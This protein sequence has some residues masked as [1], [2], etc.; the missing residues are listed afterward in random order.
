MKNWQLD[1]DQDGIAVLT[2]DMP[3]R[4]MNVLNESSMSEFGEAVEE[5]SEDEAIKGIVV[6]SGKRDF[7]AGAD[8]SMLGESAGNRGGEGQDESAPESTDSETRVKRLYQANLGFNQL[9]RRLETCGKPVAAALPGTALGGG[10]E[11]A[12]AC[13]YRVLADNPRAQIGLPEA[14]VGVMPGGGGTQRLPRMIGAMQALPLML[15]GKSLDPASAKAMGIVDEVV[16]PDQ[17]LSAAKAWILSNGD[18]VQPWD[19]PGFKIPGGGPYSRG[20]APVF[21]MGTAMLRKESHG[22]YPAQKAIMQA[23]YEGLQVPID[24]ALA[25]ESQLFTSL[26]L[27]PTARNMIRSLFLSMQELA[28]GARRPQGIGPT[29]CKKVGILGAGMMGAGI[30]YVS[31]KVGI[32]VVLIDTDQANAERGKDY[33]ATLMDK[34]ILDKR[35]T[36][37]QRTELLALIHPT[38]DYA[39]LAGCD[40][41]VE[42]VFEDREIK[43]DV[44]RRAEAVLSEDV[45][46]GSNTSTLPIT[47]LAQASKR[48]ESFIGIHF[49]SPVDRMGLVEIILGEETS[50]QAL[51]VAIDY[52]GKIKKTPIV[53][54]DS[55]GFYTSRCFGT[56]VREGL[57]M[58]AEG[59]A[60][61]LI[62]NV[63][64][65]TGMPRAPLEMNDDVSLDLSYKVGLQTKK[66]LGDQW[67]E[68]PVDGI[69][70]TMVM[71]LKR[72]GRKNG[73]GFYDYPEDGPKVLWPGLLPLIEEK[74]GHGLL[75]DQPSPD[76]VKRR[77]LYRQAVEAARCFGEGVVTDVRDADVGAILGWGFAPWTGGPLSMIDTIG[78]ARFVEQ[79]DQ[80]ADAYGERFR[81]NDLL[82]EMAASDQTFYRRFDPHAAAAA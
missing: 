34:L 44:T 76:L 3:E 31:A 13:H 57:E 67:V 48:P 15:Q 43:A 65:Q 7:A 18:A 56:Y 9:L 81:P 10:L 64:R 29:D 21:M 39:A 70:E 38:T 11:V 28:K 68:S 20:G 47:G 37:A 24:M 16:A 33:S 12:L 50:E 51:A 2:W 8:L 45:I 73:K 40:L 14:K 78:T 80:L 1:T 22:N 52:V 42:A 54:N 35:A 32:E 61:A 30:A 19:K 66:D 59:V 17:I 58:L 74:T 23:V 77:L 53:V 69:I 41:I 4:S 71:E 72:Y 25:I 82:R 27:D 55:R 79:C 36:S 26:L 49:F 6:T 62:E 46:F 60:P 5:L 75:G 63:G